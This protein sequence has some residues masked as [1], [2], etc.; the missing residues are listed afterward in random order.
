MPF[1]SPEQKKATMQMLGG[2]GK[3]KKA[4]STDLA[5]IDE[6]VTHMGSFKADDMT[7]LVTSLDQLNPDAVLDLADAVAGVFSQGEESDQDDS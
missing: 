1:A 3:K 2:S 4:S 5:L 7:Q 6:I